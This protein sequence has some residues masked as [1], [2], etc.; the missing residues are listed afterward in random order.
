MKILICKIINF[1]M[2]IYITISTI[3]K[4]YHLLKKARNVA[5]VFVL[6]AP[7]GDLVYSR[8]LPK[9]IIWPKEILLEEEIV[10]YTP[11]SGSILQA[12]MYSADKIQTNLIEILLS[13]VTY[14]QFNTLCL[15]IN[16]RDGSYIG[17]AAVVGQFSPPIRL[18]ISLKGREFKN[19]LQSS[20]HAALLAWPG[21]Q[22][23]CT[24]D[25]SQ[26]VFPTSWVFE[27]SPRLVS[28]FVNSTGLS[29]RVAL[30]ENP[31][32][33]LTTH[34]CDKLPVSGASRVYDTICNIEL[35]KLNTASQI[36]LEV[37]NFGRRAHLESIAM[38]SFSGNPP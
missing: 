9:Y 7:W 4:K 37:R 32:G 23:Q 14:S 18:V 22:G 13:N 33:P 35:C 21:N 30:Q 36:W 24:K 11:V 28:F 34:K 1:L 2:A 16:A 20:V 31:E 6:S 17:K 10:T 3:V 29:T 8:E 38:P 5:L 15:R 27:Q 26:I 25:A 12:A 19:L